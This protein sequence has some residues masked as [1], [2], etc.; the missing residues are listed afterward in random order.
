MLKRL[1]RTPLV[2]SALGALTSGYMRLVAR[3]T[4]W[5]IENPEIAAAA[6]QPGKGACVVIWHG[7]LGMIYSCWAL[8]P[9]VKDPAML[10]SLSPDAQFV[11]RGAELLGARVIRGSTHRA[12]RAQKRKGGAGAYRKMIAHVA[13]GGVLCLTPD[14]P[15][16]PRMRASLG[17]ARLAR[18]TQAP[19]LCLGVAVSRRFVV[20]SWD[21]LI[22]PLPFGRG[23][24]VWDGPIAPPAREDDADAVRADMEARLIAVTQRAD[25]LA[26]AQ[27][28]EPAPVAAA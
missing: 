1:V 4:R 10:I 15:R 8:Y 25:T 20:N 12:E 19:V 11:A 6:L 26:G 21:R 24:L 7:R 28:I 27:A 5:R 23:V 17:A 3:T 18:H 13:Q 16:G 14:G 9:A 22:V 2:Q